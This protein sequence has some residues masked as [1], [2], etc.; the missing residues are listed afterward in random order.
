MAIDLP[1]SEP[2]GAPFVGERLQVLD[3]PRR[4]C[5][6]DLVVIDDGREMRQ[7]MLARTNRPFPDRAFVD[8]AVAHDDEHTAVTFLVADSKSHPQYHRKPEAQSAGRGLKHG[9]VAGFR[10]IAENVVPKA[11]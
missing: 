5:G 6:L 1:R 4:S 8:L 3:F 9:Y 11:S 7:P 10:L 2:K